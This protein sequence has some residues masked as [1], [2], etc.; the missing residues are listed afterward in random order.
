MAARLEGTNVTFV[1]TKSGAVVDKIL[2]LDS[3]EDDEGY[4]DQRFV[5]GTLESIHSDLADVVIQG[6]TVEALRA[7]VN[8]LTHDATAQRKIAGKRGVIMVSSEGGEHKMVFLDS[9]KLDKGKEDWV[10]RL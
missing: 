7:A 8:R 5:T 2:S 10:S 9:A 1:D 4:D 3:E 6:G